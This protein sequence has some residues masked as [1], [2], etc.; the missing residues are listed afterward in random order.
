MPKLQSYSSVAVCKWS[1]ASLPEDVRHLCQILL[2]L[3]EIE[4]L[5]KIYEIYILLTLTSFS[6]NSH[7]IYGKHV[8][9]SSLVFT[10]SAL[11]LC[12]NPSHSSRNPCIHSSRP[13]KENH[14]QR[15]WFL[16]HQ[17]VLQD[18][19]RVGAVRASVAD[20]SNDNPIVHWLLVFEG[21]WTAGIAG[22]G[23]DVLVPAADLRWI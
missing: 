5:T 1:W 13:E 10:L 18:W 20:N 4:F 9:S 22:T 21:Q 16:G 12:H 7:D 17:I 14:G 3:L 6:V 23:V 19:P 11:N 8:G 15:W 2:L